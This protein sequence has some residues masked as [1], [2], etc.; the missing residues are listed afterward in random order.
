MAAGGAIAVGGAVSLGLGA[1][2]TT[3]YDQLCTPRC[4][5]DNVTMGR[6][7]YDR[8][9]TMFGIGIAGVT[10][11]GAAAVGGLLWMLVARPSAAPPRVAF[12][13]PT[14]GGM[15]IGIGGSL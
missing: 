11:G 6:A 13:A 10:I 12:V 15:V 7:A 1:A 14:A 2:A 5:Q 9:N 3:E 8:A 4:T